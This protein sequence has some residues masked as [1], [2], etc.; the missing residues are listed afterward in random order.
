MKEDFKD[1]NEKPSDEDYIAAQTHYE[2]EH[3]QCT[4][5]A[6]TIRKR[7]QLARNAM[8][9]RQTASICEAIRT[10]R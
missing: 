6:L 2:A 1:M 3:G 4:W 7:K 8:F 5:G 9:N 10:F